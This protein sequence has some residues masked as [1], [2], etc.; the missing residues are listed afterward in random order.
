MALHQARRAGR[1]QAAHAGGQDHG[2]G[3]GVELLGQLG[4]DGAVA[5]HDVAGNF[6]VARV[7]GVGDH[8]PPFALGGACAGGDA[9]IEGAAHQ[10]HLAALVLHGVHARG[11]GVVGHEDH[12][13]LAQASRGPGHGAAVVAVGGGAEGDLAEA[14]A[15]RGVGR[16]ARREVLAGEF[17]PPLPQHRVHG[18]ARAQALEGLD[19]EA[20]RLVLHQHAAQA[21]LAREARQVAQRRGRVAGQRAVQR[22]LVAAAHGLGPGQL[23]GV[24]AGCGEAVG[25]DGVAGHVSSPSR[26]RAGGRP[27]RRAAPPA[28]R[29]G[30]A[31]R[32]RPPT[33]AGPPPS[34]R[35]WRRRAR[36]APRASRRR[37]HRPCG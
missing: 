13:P 8:L 22:Q 17:T 16:R 29:R 6:Q 24:P 15:H 7:G 27:N 20:V 32:S 5:G 10:A 30:A 23:G 19:A 18:V 2:V 3:H 14:V 9:V 11:G 34:R 4:E 21:Q 28:R 33:P 26:P 35:R 37:T 25:V 36:R 12:R 1:R 31:T